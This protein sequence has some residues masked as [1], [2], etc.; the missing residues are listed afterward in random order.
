MYLAIDYGQKRIGLAL[1]Q[2]I[3]KGA[4]TIDASNTAEAILAIAK[5][6]KETEVEKIIIGL[7][8]RSQ[9]TEPLSTIKDFGISCYLRVSR[10][11]QINGHFPAS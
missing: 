3:P 4:G 9:G 2:I 6:C 7:P 10:T 1:G 8:L 11:G 5:L